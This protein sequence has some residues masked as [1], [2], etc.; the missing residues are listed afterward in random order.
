MLV[1]D[2]DGEPLGVIAHSYNGL[3]TLEPGPG[4]PE[5]L[6]LHHDDIRSVGPEEVVLMRPRDELRWVSPVPN[7]DVP[8]AELDDRD[9]VWIPLAEEEVLAERVA[10][11]SGLL[12]VRK[13][14]VTEQKTI[15]VTVPVRRE[16]LVIE[17]MPAGTSAP[18][19]GLPSGTL[20]PRGGIGEGT[21]V[22]RLHEE[23]VEIQKRAYVYEEVVITKEVVR[24]LRRLD[25]PVRREV[26]H[27]RGGEPGLT[28][29]DD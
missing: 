27:V 12:R 21:L 16:E 3:F 9:E 15:S 6:Q 18:S 1:R 24:E 28:W 10:R 14:I 25:V 7:N 8:L 13:R 11:P 29:E 23:Q 20:P 19:P 5:G 4:I 22:V 17:E 2:A 26:A